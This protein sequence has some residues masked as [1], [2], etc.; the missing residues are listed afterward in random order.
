MHH[1]LLQL[2]CYERGILTKDNTDGLDL[3]WGNAEAMLALVE[4]I[5]YR[6][7]FGDFVADGV[8]RMSEVLGPETK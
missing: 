1:H 5:A 7:G 2:E 3:S 8:K 6:E 4:K